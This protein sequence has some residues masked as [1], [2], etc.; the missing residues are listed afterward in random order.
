MCRAVV[1]RRSSARRASGSAVCAAESGQGSAG[2]TRSTTRGRRSGN[3]A[4]ITHPASAAANATPGGTREPRRGRRSVCRCRSPGMRDRSASASG[5]AAMPCVVTSTVRRQ[6]RSTSAGALPRTESAAWCAARASVSPAAPPDAASPSLPF[7]FS[8]TAESAA[9]GRPSPR[10]SL[11]SK[12]RRTATSIISRRTRPDS[13]AA[14]MAS[15]A[16]RSF[17]TPTSR[18]APAETA[19]TAASPPP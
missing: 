5:R 9:A 2:A 13:T 10:C 3:A 8:A 18:S 4:T 12:I 6:P 1:S 7:S 16:S 17:S 14:T 11:A 15:M 19:R